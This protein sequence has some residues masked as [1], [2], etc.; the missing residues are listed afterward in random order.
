MRSLA[1]LLCL[2]WVAPVW[3]GPFGTEMGDSPEKF[4]GLEKYGQHWGLDVYITANPPQKHS[5]FEKYIFGFHEAKLAIIVATTQDYGDDRYGYTARS[6]Y[7]I[8][9]KQLTEKYGKPLCSESLNVGSI[10]DQPQDF[11]TS[12]NKNERTHGCTWR[13]ELPDNLESIHLQIATKNRNTTYLVLRY[14]YK[15]IVNARE[16]KKGVDQGAL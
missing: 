3:A 2:F 12:I 1:L 5:S 11:S 9:K 6:K 8:V 13:K 14:A 4:T 15:N 10:W 16:K 7:D